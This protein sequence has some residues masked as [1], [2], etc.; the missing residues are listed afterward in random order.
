MKMNGTL[1][2]PALFGV[3]FQIQIYACKVYHTVQSN[4]FSMYYTL[5]NINLMEKCLK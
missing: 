1:C 2:H 3:L 5:L 4:E